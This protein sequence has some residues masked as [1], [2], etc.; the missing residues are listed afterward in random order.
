MLDAYTHQPRLEEPQKITNFELPPYEDLLR[1]VLSDRSLVDR[2]D[3]LSR[4][5][6]LRFCDV[7]DPEHEHPVINV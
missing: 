1:E 3:S 4:P 2:V 5:E 7:E 6:G